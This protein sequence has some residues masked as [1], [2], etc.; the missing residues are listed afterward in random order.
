MAELALQDVLKWT[1]GEL[2]GGQPEACFGSVCTDSRKIEPGCLF[3]ALRGQQFDGHLFLANAL[4]AGAGGLLIDDRAALAS[5]PDSQ[6]RPVI[7]ATNTLAALQAIAA[8]YRQ[9]LPG[10]VIGITGSVGKT[11]TREMIS[12]CLKPALQVHQTP[13]NLNNEIGMPLT[14]LQAG[15]GHEAVVLEMGMRGPGE[16]SLL[17]RIASPDIAVLTC[18][19]F[20]HIGRLGS[21][22]AILEAKAEIL[23]GLRPEGLLILN[24]DD[25]LLNSFGRRQAG[26]YRLACVTTSREKAC[27]MTADTAAGVSFALLADDIRSED[28]QTF[29]T[30]CLFIAGSCRQNI[31]VSLPFPGTHHVLNTLFGLAAARELQVDLVQAAAGA[32]TCQNTGNRQRILQAA[33]IT[34]M[35]DS[36]NASPESMLAALR[37]LAGLAAGGRRK[38]AALGGMLELGDYEE[39]AHRELGEQVAR[40]GFDLLL[41][42][43][44]QSAS[45]EAG[46]HLVSPGLPVGCYPDNLTLAKALEPLL[47][48]GDYLLVKASRSFAMEKVTEYLLEQ[49]APPAGRKPE[50]EQ[51]VD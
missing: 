41:V 9:T 37:T 33:D 38:I 20:S 28:G 27:E 43:G 1:G 3:V 18:I 5:Q 22:Q 42:T 48:P 7:L 34:I 40:C 23:E 51:H 4:A 10:K 12:A 11:S 15:S 35:D 49:L 25:P 47:Q 32:A 2:I 29:F 31:A 16:I 21:Q 36:Y 24:A 50:N 6:D 30:A 17:S 19:G 8:G 13:G 45:V 26:R 39:A 14:L 44:P 46:A